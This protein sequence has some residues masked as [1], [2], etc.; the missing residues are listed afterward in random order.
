MAPW[1]EG[2]PCVI[3]A[4][5]GFLSFGAIHGGDSSRQRDLFSERHIGG[6][7]WVGS[8]LIVGGAEVLTIDRY[9]KRPSTA[10]EPRE[11]GGAGIF[12]GVEVQSR[13]PE[14]Q[15]L[16]MG[17]GKHHLLT[18]NRLQELASIKSPPPLEF[19]SVAQLILESVQR[20]L[21]FD[22]AWI[23]KFEPSSLNILDIYLHQFSQKAFSR[24]LDHFYGN[25][26]LPAIHEIREM[27]FI[28]K[29][30]SDLVENAVWIESPFFKEVIAPLGLQ[31]FLLGACVNEKEEY[32][33]LIVLWRSRGRHDF[34]SRDCHFLAKASVF[35]ARLLAKIQPIE[36]GTENSEILELIQRRSSPGVILL[37]QNNDILYI[38]REAKSMLKLLNS[39]R[40]C[41][42]AADEERFMQKLQQLKERT[43]AEDLLSTHSI[44]GAPPCEVFTFRGTSFSC[45]GIRLEDDVHGGKSSAMILIEQIK[46]NGHPLRSANT[47]DV[48]F[49][50]REG[51]VVGLIG[52]GLTNKEIA[53]E[54]GIGIHTVK[55]HIK[56]IMGK[57]GTHTRSGIVAKLMN[58]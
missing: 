12:T 14:K 19:G 37:G 45:R 57:L 26:L 44:E 49:T 18:L 5:P 42:S 25:T 20:A 31:F 8:P 24:Y 16:K 35:C 4:A 36:S 2:S 54:L 7:R 13:F 48:D 30:S 33:G 21:R 40:G 38:N 39:G 46:E 52:R 41:L 43:L 6:P 32:T 3:G 56:H 17:L 47:P 23:F 53:S 50:A 27:G 29:R 1:I 22:G 10:L 9:P 34:S 15:R 58:K 11:N 51:A 28:S 55:D